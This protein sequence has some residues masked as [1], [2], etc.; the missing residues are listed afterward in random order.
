M[1]FSTVCCAEI[2]YL[3]FSKVKQKRGI[4]LELRRRIFCQN[5]AVCGLGSDAVVECWRRKIA[6]VVGAIR[7]KE[8]F[9]L[10]LVVTRR[11]SGGEPY[12]VLSINTMIVLI[13][14]RHW[15]PVSRGVRLLPG[16]DFTEIFS[17]IWMKYFQHPTECS[18]Y[19]VCVFGGPLLESCTGK[20]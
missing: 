1:L 10:I 11:G 9:W 2:W 7:E 5:W 8:L 20:E 17:Q 15:V 6:I 14:R 3:T 12:F 19:Y 13:V 18:L 16:N 4:N